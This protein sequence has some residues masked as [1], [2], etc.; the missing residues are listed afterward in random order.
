MILN[1]FSFFE[2]KISFLV[3][4]NYGQSLHSK[5][6][7]IQDC[8]LSKMDFHSLMKKKLGGKYDQP[9]LA[10]DDMAELDD[11]AKENNMAKTHH[12]LDFWVW[13]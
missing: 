10:A 11:M 2:G 5:V 13:L 6:F 1:T 7:L 12:P 3:R 8:R 9:K 4:K